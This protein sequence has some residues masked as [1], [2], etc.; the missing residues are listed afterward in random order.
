MCIYQPSNHPPIAAP[1]ARAG[2]VAVQ[3]NP[4]SVQNG[5]LD[6]ACHEPLICGLMG[7]LWF[8]MAHMM[9]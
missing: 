9:A 3:G 7:K 5:A 1:G 2:Y 6:P 8:N 4:V